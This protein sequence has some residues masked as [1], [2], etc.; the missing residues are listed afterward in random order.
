MQSA[1]GPGNSCTAFVGVGTEIKLQGLSCDTA[2]P[3]SPEIVLSSHEKT[4]VIPPCATLD[5]FVKEANK[6]DI[7]F[8]VD[9][10]GRVVVSS[11][12]GVFGD[13]SGIAG[14]YK[15]ANG[16]QRS[17]FAND[18]GTFSVELRAKH[19]EIPQP[20]LVMEA[21]DSTDR[22]QH[23][24]LTQ[25]DGSAPG[26]AFIQGVP[27]LEGSD[28]TLSMGDQV[29]G[30]FTTMT[31]NERATTQHQV[32]PD[33]I[34]LDKDKKVCGDSALGVTR[35]RL[36]LHGAGEK[37]LMDS[38]VIGACL[39]ARPDTALCSFRMRVGE[40]KKMQR[41][42]LVAPFPTDAEYMVIDRNSSTGR[43]QVFG[44]V[45]GVR[46]LCLRSTVA[47]DQSAVLF[48]QAID[49][50]TMERPTEQT[51]FS[52]PDT[53]EGSL[54]FVF[55]S[56]YMTQ[57][58]FVS[59]VF[60][61][62]INNGIFTV[63]GHVVSGLPPLVADKPYMVFIERNG[64][65]ITVQYIRIDDTTINEEVVVNNPTGYSSSGYTGHIHMFTQETVFGDILLTNRYIDVDLS[66]K[67]YEFIL[68]KYTVDPFR[69]LGEYD[70]S[71]K[72]FTDG[73]TLD[74]SVLT[75]DGTTYSKVLLSMSQSGVDFLQLRSEQLQSKNI[76]HAP[77]YKE[78]A[79]SYVVV[80]DGIGLT[81]TVNGQRILAEVPTSLDCSGT[82]T[83]SYRYPG[84][85]KFTVLYRDNLD[86]ALKPLPD[87]ANVSI[88]FS[89]N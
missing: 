47:I 62:S 45:D 71:S 72:T 1:S 75:V 85:C 70:L 86:G 34:V 33:E 35:V 22:N 40:P 57:D 29:A 24:E 10:A 81:N 9:K 50:I 38:P 84:L 28:F 87:T 67:W 4:E 76:G 7:D 51:I 21:G 17:V 6:T 89:V 48:L 65:S 12:G 20:F 58:L 42:E 3:F 78:R 2:L 73:S 46:T 74:G 83:L 39:Q 80:A 68:R 32:N 37:L 8:R 5:T 43:L 61:V 23:K 30:E 14:L 66:N 11:D 82:Q 27:C 15:S 26:V 31:L 52:M 41:I 69:V 13:E 60:I 44:E 55:Q 16:R 19:P 56:Q 54:Y 36:H 25:V 88:R 18:D 64:D 63:N 59:H 49:D 79:A 53:D 77:V